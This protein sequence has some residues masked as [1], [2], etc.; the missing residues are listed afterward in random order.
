MSFVFFP[1]LVLLTETEAAK[2]IFRHRF[3]GIWG[4]ISFHAYIWHYPMFWAMCLTTHILNI[5][6]YYAQRKWMYL[7]CFLVMAVG[8][9]SF[10][11]I[12]KPLNRFILKKRSGNTSLAEKPREEMCI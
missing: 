10:Y 12:E 8:F 4:Q 9:V 2:R 6:P 5:T 1:G 3:W 11:C 7:F